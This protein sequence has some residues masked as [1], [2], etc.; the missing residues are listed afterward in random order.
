MRDQLTQLARAALGP[1]GRGDAT[2]TDCL[3][4]GFLTAWP[5][6]ARPG[7]SA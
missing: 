6:G 1:E 2:L 4:A 5:G 3:L 7:A